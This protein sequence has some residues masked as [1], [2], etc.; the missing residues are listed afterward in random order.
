MTGPAD[1]SRHTES[2]HYEVGGNVSAIEIEATQCAVQPPSTVRAWPVT[3]A[4]PA[5]AR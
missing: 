5:L 2:R 1:T 3:E 4:A